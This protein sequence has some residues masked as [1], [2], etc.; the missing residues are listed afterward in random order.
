MLRS[1]CTISEYA[2]LTEEEKAELLSS[3]QVNTPVA[4]G[5]KSGNSLG[6]GCWEPSRP[7]T[8]G[9]GG[10][11]A[12]DWGVDGAGALGGLDRGGFDE[13]RRSDARTSGAI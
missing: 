11:V 8:E 2:A 1:Q 7:R 9:E 12:L 3:P 4:T 6:G 5:T 13:F 10:E